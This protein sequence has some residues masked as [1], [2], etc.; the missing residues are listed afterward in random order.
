VREHGALRL[1]RGA[2]RVDDEARMVGLDLQRGARVRCAGDRLVPPHVAPRRPRDLAAEPPV[3][4]DALDARTRRHRLVGRLLHL[5]DLAAPIEAVG[6]DQHPGLAVLEPRGD[7][8]GPE[9][10]E[11]RRVDRA[12][13]HD[14]ERGDGGLGRHR[15]EDA[16]AVAGADAE[17]LQRVGEP[18]DLRR[19]LRIGQ[20]ATRAVVALPDDRGLGAAPGIEVAIEAVVGEVQPAADEP[21]RPR[22]AA[23]GVEHAAERLREADAEV[24]D[25]AAPVPLGVV[26]RAAL[27]LFQ[28]ADAQ[29]AHEAGD[30]RALDVLGSGPPNDLFAHRGP[31]ISLRA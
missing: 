3:D 14:G 11:A 8:L 19:Q 12:D 23:R 1:P 7:G 31:M 25:H 6:G 30:L 9:A 4:D 10:R 28:R 29:A 13:A 24:L 20:R 27:Q 26:H 21:A 2:G 15:Q 18:I 17:R 16:D 22:R 5:H